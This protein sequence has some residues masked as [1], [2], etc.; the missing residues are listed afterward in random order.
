MV[1]MVV[2][3]VVAAEAAAEGEEVAEALDARYTRRTMMVHQ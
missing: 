3:T 1:A 2:A